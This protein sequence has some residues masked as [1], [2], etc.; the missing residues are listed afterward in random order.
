MSSLIVTGAQVLSQAP[1]P[2]RAP[3]PKREWSYVEAFAGF[4]LR[5][6]EWAARAEQRKLAR[7][8]DEEVR[9]G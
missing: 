8:R 2:P 9:G 3:W 5:H 4:A 7:L 1:P 6:P